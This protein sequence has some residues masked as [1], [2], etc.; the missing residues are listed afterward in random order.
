MHRPPRM[1]MKSGLFAMRR[2]YRRR[3]GR[4]FWRGIVGRFLGEDCGGDERLIMVLLLLV[5]TTGAKHQRFRKTSVLICFGIVTCTVCCN[6]N[7]ISH[8]L[9][10]HAKMLSDTL[11]SY[12]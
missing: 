12:V 6:F 8:G 2:F 3:R 5:D 4:G 10:H 7:R 11:L 9:F 1:G